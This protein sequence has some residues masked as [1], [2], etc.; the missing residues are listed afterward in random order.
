MSGQTFAT[1]AGHAGRTS[2]SMEGRTIV[3]PDLLVDFLVTTLPVSLQWRAGQLSGQTALRMPRRDAPL[4][5]SM[6]GRT[7]VRPDPK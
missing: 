2:P 4:H 3:R 7:I 6:E 1:G 5:P